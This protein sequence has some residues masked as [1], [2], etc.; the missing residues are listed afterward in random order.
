MANVLVIADIQVEESEIKTTGKGD[1][2]PIYAQTTF[3]ISEDGSF[4]IVNSEPARKTLNYNPYAHIVGDAPT[5]CPTEA[6]RAMLAAVYLRRSKE[7]PAPLGSTVCGWAFQGMTPDKV[8]EKYG[9]GATVYL[10]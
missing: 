6:Q 8:S 4:R 3:E 2:R 9:T 10:A 5:E 1:N 7:F